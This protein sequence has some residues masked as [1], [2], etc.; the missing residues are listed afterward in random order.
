MHGLHAFKKKYTGA[1]QLGCLH[2]A[3][4]TK[5]GH[6]VSSHVEATPAWPPFF[7]RCSLANSSCLPTYLPDHPPKQAQNSHVPPTWLLHNNQQPDKGNH[8]AKAEK[9]FKP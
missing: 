1:P 8:R 7:T 3:P 6:L 2:L 9:S 4:R 5:V